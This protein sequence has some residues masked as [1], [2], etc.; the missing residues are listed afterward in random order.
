MKEYFNFLGLPTVVQD[1]I[2]AEI[3][4]NS[5]PEDRIQFSLT[6]KAFNELV[7]HAKPK[8][9]LPSV[10]IG[11]CKKDGTI[12]YTLSSVPED[13]TFFHDDTM[14]TT[15]EKWLRNAQIEILTLS[16]S[17]FSDEFKNHVEFLNV[18]YEATRFVTT[19]H[20]EADSS[21]NSGYL[22]FYQKLKHLKRLGFEGRIEEFAKLSKIPSD[23]NLSIYYHHTGISAFVKKLATV[24]LSRLHLEPPLNEKQ[25]QEL[26]KTLKFKDNAEIY[27]RVYDSNRHSAVHMR[28]IGQDLFEI[29]LSLGIFI[30]IC[31]RR[32]RYMKQNERVLSLT[33]TITG[34]FPFYVTTSSNPNQP[35]FSSEMRNNAESFH[36]ENV[37][38]NEWMKVNFLYIEY[39]RVIPH[40][41]DELLDQW[42][43]RNEYDNPFER[44]ETIN[45]ALGT[46]IT[47]IKP[48]ILVETLKKT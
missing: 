27:F 3:V 25:C 48:E 20:I 37:D 1:L 35:I 47:I 11:R 23:L 21:L 36:I 28:Y 44:V 12:S 19:L 24:Q 4:H 16:T 30:T 40:Y 34:C 42:F 5:I 13:Y 41:A 33:N 10:C 15:M 18:F 43:P 26:I 17:I 29:Q 31:E 45:K 2:A 6:C 9:I 38:Q 8:K 22:D 32:S 39:C 14:A 7:K 46:T